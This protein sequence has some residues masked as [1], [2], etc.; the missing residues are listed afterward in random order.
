MICD[1]KCAFILV[2]VTKS[3][4][5]RRRRTPPRPI[6]CGYTRHLGSGFSETQQSGTWCSIEI[7]GHH[8]PALRPAVRF[9]SEVY[10][11]C[12]HYVLYVNVRNKASNVWKLL[13]ACLDSLQKVC[14]SF[15]QVHVEV[16]AAAAA[17]EVPAAAAVPLKV[18]IAG[19]EGAI[20]LRWVQLQRCGR[21][22]GLFICTPFTFSSMTAFC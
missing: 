6:S 17:S 1:M 14:G 10:I 9:C 8:S 13:P 2:D 11:V 3:L 12:T 15:F 20:G 18:L 22:R 16:P 19:T 21:A 5:P 4:L 7:A